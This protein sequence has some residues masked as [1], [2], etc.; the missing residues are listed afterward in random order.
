MELSTDEKKVIK[1]A[2]ERHL[3][4]VKSAEDMPDQDVPIVA[5][6]H[7]YDE[8]VESIIKKME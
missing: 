7:K 6:E 4:E 1:L 5:V 3:D 8:F 2:L